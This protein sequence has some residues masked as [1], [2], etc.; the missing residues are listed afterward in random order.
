V[1][2]SAANLEPCAVVLHNLAS[3]LRASQLYKDALEGQKLAEEANSLKSRFM[4]MVSHELRGL[5]SLI[6]GLSDMILREQPEPSGGTL[7][8]IKQISASAQYLAHL[9]GDVLDLASSEAGQLRIL[10]EQ[11]DLSEVV[12][13]K[14]K[15]GKSIVCQSDNK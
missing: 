2:F 15:I 3:A 11:L 9:I 8:D 7:R 6:V 12:Q 10:R 14:G 4:S 1:A 5:P 13:V